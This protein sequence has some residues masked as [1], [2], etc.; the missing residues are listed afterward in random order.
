MGKEFIMIFSKRRWRL[1]KSA[2]EKLLEVSLASCRRCRR[3]PTSRPAESMLYIGL[4][5]CSLCCAR[6]RHAARGE[7]RQA[8]A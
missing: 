2:S 1:S 4:V 5:G 8:A 3:S 7:E 6:A